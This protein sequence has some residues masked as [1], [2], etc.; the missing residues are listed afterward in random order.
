MS[1]VKLLCVIKVLLHKLMWMHLILQAF[2]RMILVFNLFAFNTFLYS[3][4]LVEI[5]SC[6][7]HLIF[8]KYSVASA[9]PSL[10]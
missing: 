9:F 10:P 7:H 5:L 6:L 8:I 2:P 1:R 3:L 4:T